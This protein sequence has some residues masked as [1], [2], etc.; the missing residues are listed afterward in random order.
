MAV[1][2]PSE[3][4]DKIHC[5][6]LPL[7]RIIRNCPMLDSYLG[8]TILSQSKFWQLSVEEVFVGTGSMYQD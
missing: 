1:S 5:G 7:L 4:E 2:S 8:D 3:A 6:F